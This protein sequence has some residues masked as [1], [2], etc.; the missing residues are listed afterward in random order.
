MKKSH[1]DC[2]TCRQPLWDDETFQSIWREHGGGSS[3]RMTG[4]RMGHNGGVPVDQQRTTTQQRR[5]PESAGFP[6]CRVCYIVNILIFVAGTG[7]LILSIVLATSNNDSKMNMDDESPCSSEVLASSTNTS[8]G[9]GSCENGTLACREAA[10]CISIG[11]G[12]C[13]GD[14][15]CQRLRVNVGNNSCQ[16]VRACRGG[17]RVGVGDNACI[18]VEAC[19]CHFPMSGVPGFSP[20][21]D[22]PDGRCTTAD[23]ECCNPPW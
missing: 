12:S 11:S 19:A 8:I 16:G 15:A 5:R 14:E 3:I 21:D 10:P 4:S 23:E 7:Y 2:P 17:L 6:W 13:N 9:L 18:G 22:V 20:Y 1:D